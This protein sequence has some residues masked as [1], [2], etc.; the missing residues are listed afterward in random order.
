MQ[1]LTKRKQEQRRR[2]KAEEDKKKKARDKLDNLLAEKQQKK[3][4][5]AKKDKAKNKLDQLVGQALNTQARTSLPLGVSIIDRLRNHIAVC[6]NPPP[7]AAGADSLIV[8]IIVRL[9]NRAEV[10][11]VEIKDRNRFNRDATFQ[12]AANAASRAIIDCSPLP[13]PLDNHDAWKELEFEFNPNF[14]TRR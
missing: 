6:W 13:L 7:G 12:A 14:I 5:Q 2:E 11:N 8:D 3:A 1:D 9:N 4:D 10:M